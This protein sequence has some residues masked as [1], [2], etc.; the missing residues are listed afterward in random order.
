MPRWADLN[1]RQQQ[2]L[3]A[4]YETYQEQEADERS[5]WKRGGTPRPARK[6]RWMKYGVLNGVG[7]TLYTKLYLCKLIDERTGSTF[8]ALILC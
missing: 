1:E 7:S 5:L 3:Q 6:W 2:Y 8:N 4:I